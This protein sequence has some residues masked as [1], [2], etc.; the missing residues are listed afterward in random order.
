MAEQPKELLKRMRQGN[1]TVNFGL[2]PGPPLPP[3]SKSLMPPQLTAADSGQS[4]SSGRESPDSASSSQYSEERAILEAL[5]DFVF[6]VSLKGAVLYASPQTLKVLGYTMQELLST[7]ISDIWYVLCSWCTTLRLTIVILPQS[8]E[9]CRARRQRAE[10]G[11]S[12]HFSY[13]QRY[14]PGSLQIWKHFLDGRQWQA[15]G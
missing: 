7:N 14:I 11:S 13:H 4:S 5:Y 6:V 2:L 9:R 1:Y 8:S 12:K 15:A 3:P 10:G